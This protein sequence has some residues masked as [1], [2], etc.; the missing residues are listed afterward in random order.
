MNPVL[1]EKFGRVFKEGDVIF[2][3]FE[4]GKNCYVIHEGQVAITKVSEG[5]EKTLAILKPGDIFGEMGVLEHKPRTATALAMTEVTVLELDLAGLKALVKAQP[6]F[7]A[8][9]GRILSHRIVQ[10]YRHLANLSIENPRLRVVDM[11]LWKAVEQETGPPLVP[12]SPE[13]I[14]EFAG[15]E[16]P[17]VTRALKEFSELSRV[18]IYQD[19]IELTDVRSLKRLLRP[20]G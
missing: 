6:A 18:K 4:E 5:V 16:L 11:L 2:C 12:L 9:L 8:R 15:L 10:S 14:A 19:H 3:E 17:E 1:L 20:G 13:E 7:A